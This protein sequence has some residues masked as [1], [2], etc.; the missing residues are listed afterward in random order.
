[1]VGET[2]SRRQLGESRSYLSLKGSANEMEMRWS[3]T[4]VNG[5]I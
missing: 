1:M 4:K 3:V 5:S 2:K